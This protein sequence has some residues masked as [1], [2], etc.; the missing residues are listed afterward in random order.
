MEKITPRWQP[1]EKECL[2]SILESLIYEGLLATRQK[3]GYSAGYQVDADFWMNIAVAYEKLRQHADLMR[4]IADFI[5]YFW[6]PEESSRVFVPLAEIGLTP[7]ALIAGLVRSWQAEWRADGPTVFVEMVTPAVAQFV[8][9]RRP[10]L[11]HVITFLGPNLRHVCATWGLRPEQY[12]ALVSRDTLDALD[13]HVRWNMI[14][15]TT[16][17]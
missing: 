1:N 11:K 5:P 8:Q 13:P 3:L 17:L 10:Q 4:T 6:L 9:A 7:S 15:G 12:N 14:Y 16:L 2:L